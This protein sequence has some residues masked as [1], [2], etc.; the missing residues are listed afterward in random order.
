MKDTATKIILQA[1]NVLFLYNVQG[2]SYGILLGLFFLSLQDAFSIY[3]SLIGSIKWY[4]FIVFGVLL[5]NIKPLI[6][7]TYINPK[8]EMHLK[9]VR[10]TLNESNLSD[11]E[12]KLIWK[13]TIQ[14]I[15]T[16]LSK[17][18]NITESANNSTNGVVD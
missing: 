10:E 18:I 2:T 9:Y 12:K 17:G 7:K 8:I 13:E 15:S 11:K 1:I 3:A 5:F 16:E 4:G 6:S 14:S